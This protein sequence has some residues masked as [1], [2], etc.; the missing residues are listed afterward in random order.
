M[1]SID[2]V[3]EFIFF[4]IFAV[5]DILA[6][7]SLMGIYVIIWRSRQPNID[8]QIYI[9]SVKSGLTVT[10]ILLPGGF[11]AARGLNNGENAIQ[12]TEAGVYL[13]SFWF[14]FSAISGILILFA[15]PTTV[16]NYGEE[17]DNERTILKKSWMIYFGALQLGLLGIGSARLFVSFIL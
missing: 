1:I 13:A 15:L 2:S 11:I 7:V 12:V 10:S 8:L 3:T 16:A 5:F 6:I 4:P 14:V 17:G 9:E